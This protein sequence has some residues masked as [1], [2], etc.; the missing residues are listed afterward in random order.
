MKIRDEAAASEGAA[1]VGRQERRRRKLHDQ[2]Y[3]TAVDLFVAQ[4][5]EATSMEQ[6]AEAADV[7]R[8]TV[9]NHFSQKVGFLEEWGVRRRALVNE[10]LGSQHAEDLPVGDGLRRY[11]K[12]MVDLNVVSRAETTVLMDASARYGRLLQDPSLEIELSR[13]VE[14][15]QQRGEIR[16]D[17][18]CDQAGQLLAACY[19]TAILR[20]IREEPAPFDLHQRL[21]G[22]LDIVLLGLLVGEA[23]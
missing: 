21:T 18:D 13:I 10:I 12:E 7:A 20:W 2:L 3:E 16:A 15:G 11:L 8:A 22:A 1:A 19:F 6:I 14:Q 5:F 23:V 4:G 17:V 9:F